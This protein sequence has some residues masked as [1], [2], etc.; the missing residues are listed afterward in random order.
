MSISLGIVKIDYD[1]PDSNRKS[2][3]KLIQAAA[4][5]SD[6]GPWVVQDEGQ[7]FIEKE[8]RPRAT[9]HGSS[10]RIRT[11]PNRTRTYRTYCPAWKSG[12]R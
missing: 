10:R 12:C 2:V 7:I 3:I 8:K 9:P 5:E 6:Y 1:L 4:E 11:A